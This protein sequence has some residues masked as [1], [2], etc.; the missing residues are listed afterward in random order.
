MDEPAQGVV[1]GRRGFTLPEILIVVSLIGLGAAVAAPLI[2]EAVRS[3]RIR[4]AA[5]ELAVSLRAARM[6]AVSANR[7]VD[8]GIVVDDPTLGTYYEFLDNRGNQQRV[9]LPDGIRVDTGASAL[10]LQFLP[11][12][13]VV[14]GPLQIVLESGVFVGGALQS[15]ER[16]TVET[17]TVGVTVVNHERV[18]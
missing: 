7:A 3:A 10:A 17:N 8:V 1:A 18:G 9:T 15:G 5:Q 6:I 12:G 13:S 16:W 4:M 11:N 14:N 2:S